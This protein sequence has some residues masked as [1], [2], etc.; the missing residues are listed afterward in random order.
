M[1][2]E[3]VWTCERSV[4]VEVPASFAWDYMTD[5]RNWSDPPA[6]FALDG[7]FAAGARG[8]TRMPGRPAVHWA[9]DMVDAGHAY[10]IR[11]SLSE[12][13][14]ILFHWRFEPRLE[15]GTRVTQRLELF[16][17]DA[18]DQIGE[19]RAAFESN[20]EPGMQRIGR[21]MQASARAS[22]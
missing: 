12:R 8:T 16:G 20:L 18:A 17:E 7:P 13:V 15:G 11:S 14:W 5:L 6:E 22:R 21:L 4:D 2:I 9:I 3:P 19:V 1:R 10:T